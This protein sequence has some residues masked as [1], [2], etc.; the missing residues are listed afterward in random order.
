MK[1]KEVEICEVVEIRLFR[2]VCCCSIWSHWFHSWILTSYVA[3][4]IQI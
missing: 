3:G 1:K 4:K 2:F